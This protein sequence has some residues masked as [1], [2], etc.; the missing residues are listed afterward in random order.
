MNTSN[1]ATQFPEK[2]AYT[3]ATRIANSRV[4][5]GASFFDSSDAIQEIV[6]KAWTN[7]SKFDPSKGKPEQF[8]A[9]LSVNVINSLWRKALAEKTRFAD[10]DQ[11][12]EYGEYSESD[13]LDQYALSSLA[14]PEETY[15]QAVAYE[16]GRKVL[17]DHTPDEA[18]AVVWSIVTGKRVATEAKLNASGA[19][20]LTPSER[21]RRY[22]QR[23]QVTRAL[24][25]VIC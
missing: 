1:T 12:D 3:I 23:I 7:W 24:E 5:N 4:K 14:D 18:D 16:A 11:H 19:T 10:L 13:P 8:L 9:R 20:N 21:N 2:L 17:E 25:R 22:H 15:F 6:I